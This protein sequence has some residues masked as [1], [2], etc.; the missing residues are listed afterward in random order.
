[1]KDSYKVYWNNVLIGEVVITG[2]DMWY[3]D[4]T[5]NGYDND[6]C[7][8][9]EKQAAT[10]ILKEVIQNPDLS[11]VLKVVLVNANNG[12]IYCLV[13]KLEKPDLFMRQV[14]AEET[15]QKF[16]PDR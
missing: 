5:W 11:K 10:Q 8:T 3:L 9:F 2:V 14:V 13:M 4:C 12:K 16:F 1:M 7:K 15:L 6:D